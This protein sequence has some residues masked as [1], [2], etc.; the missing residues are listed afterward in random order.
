MTE[1]QDLFARLGFDKSAPQPVGLTGYLI[2]LFVSRLTGAEIAKRRREGF[3]L[4]LSDPVM[5]G[6]RDIRSRG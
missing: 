1:A 5:D 4:G 3:Y 6:Y 2:D